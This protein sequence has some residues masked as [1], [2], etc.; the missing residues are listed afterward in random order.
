ME[1]SLF[2]KLGIVALA[3]IVGLASTWVFKMKQDNIVEEVA[4]EVIKKE[5][6]IT[7]ELTPDPAPTET[8]EKK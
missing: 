7:V 6:G 4:E 1:T 8:Q 2:L 5:T 3:T